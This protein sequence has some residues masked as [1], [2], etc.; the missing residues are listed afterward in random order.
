MGLLAHDCYCAVPTE[1]PAGAPRCTTLGRSLCTFGIGR[2]AC[3]CRFG[4]PTERVGDSLLGEA[5]GL[6][7]RVVLA[8][9]AC[10]VVAF[11]QEGLR[12][13]ND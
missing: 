1:I 2:A 3:S 4:S 13:T 6:A 12:L 9:H 8:R 5:L 7:I 11:D 10:E